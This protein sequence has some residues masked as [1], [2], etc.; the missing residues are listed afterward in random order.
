MT[1][2][3]KVSELLPAH[4]L[5]KAVDTPKP[6]QASLYQQA[7]HYGESK[8]I[9]ATW[10]SFGLATFAGAFIALAFVFF[11]TVTT[12]NDGSSWGLVRLV[13]GLA[14]SL[15]LMLVVICGGELFTSTVLS[16]VA[17]A[18]K[19]VTTPDLIKCWCRVYAGNLLGAM[20][21]LALIMSARMH[22]L[23]GGQ[24]GLNALQIAQHKL[25]HGWMQ[26]FVLGI[27]CNMLVCLG[28][29]MTFAS[30]DALTKAILLMLPVAMF[31]SSGFEHSIANLF[32][33]PLGIAIS[34]FAQ[35]E[36]FTSLGINSAQFADLTLS[37]FIF[38]N[39]IP[40]TLGNIVG[41]GVFVGLGYW[42]I[43][44]SVPAVQVPSAH[45]V[46]QFEISA[47]IYPL[48]PSGVSIKMPKII[49][50]L[51]VQDLMDTNPLTISAELS[52][53]AGLTLLADNDCRSAPVLDEQKRLLGFI[54]QQDLLR[55]LWSEEFARGV[56]YKVSDLMQKEVMTL[57]PLDPV[58]ELI[59]L[60]VVDRNKL[61]PVNEN[62][63]LT[64]NTFTSYEER[65]RC[66]SADK[67]SMFPVLDKG[68]LCG[69]ITR[70]AIAKKVCDIYK[71]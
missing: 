34:Q 62:G 21:M 10:Q 25:H 14:F 11:I 8:V 27:L 49:Q 22:E 9:K 5:H 41:G 48:L 28:V 70:D 61:F 18:Q 63:I 58:A 42:L 19:L 16:S 4:S 3:N 64:G 39:L 68:V 36:F 59:E 69:V 47:Q 37:H 54:S 50:K 51:R 6:V 26:A 13:G 2:T 67:P 24:W 20:I 44:K 57:S 33:V 60:M 17:W 40:V 56:S 32:M 66:A 45:S 65:L 35:P 15:G 1:S 52:V 31:V 12:G 55:S 53:Y 46:P 71:V 30:K 38:N 23:D 29:W 7:E 43:E